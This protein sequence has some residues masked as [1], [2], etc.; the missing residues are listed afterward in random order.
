MTKKQV[1]NG[2]VVSEITLAEVLADPAMFF[3]FLKIVDKKGRIIPL[4]LNVEQEQMLNLYKT[5]EDKNIVIL[6]PRQIGSSTFFAALLFWKWYTAVD[7]V[8]IISMSHTHDSAQNFNRMHKCFWDNLPDFMKIRTLSKA[9]TQVMELEDTGA[10]LEVRTAGGK[11]GIRSFSCNIL[12]I[13]EYA[14]CSD[15]E[16]LLAT[17]IPALNDGL[18]IIESTPNYH[19]DALHKIINEAAGDNSNWIFHFFSW[20]D[21]WAYRIPRVTVEMTEEEKIL[22]KD[23]KLSGLQI[24]WRRK[25]ISEMGWSKFKRDYPLTIDDAY[26]QTGDAWMIE[27][28]LQTLHSINI[29]ND[30]SDTLVI[31]HPT[32]REKYA[33]GSDIAAGVGKDYSVLYV[34]SCKT[35]NPVYCFRSNVIKPSDMAHKIQEVSTRYNGAKV[36]AERNS[37]GE[38]I[39]SEFKHI[40]F[41]NFWR[42]DRGEPWLTTGKNKPIIIQNLR[43]YI[44]NGVMK[45]IDGWALDQLRSLRIDKKGD[46]DFNSKDNFNGHY[47]NIM[48]LA[49]AQAC[50]DTI[51]MMDARSHYKNALEVSIAREQEVQRRQAYRGVR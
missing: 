6:K 1:R 42:D 10:S 36:L 37:I 45:V 35:R 15:P 25:K 18:L 46:P 23:H 34:V 3:G 5:R 43:K 32:P 33:I 24:A 20:K 41:H 29:A 28:E 17:A 12:H 11:G 8:K 2:P 48:A 13:S 50:A 7:P 39:Y 4:K 19:G 26:S 40:G 44:A 30:I 9:N 49:L 21:H 47:D 27:E 16:E 14:F 22:A 38:V 31:E 51:P